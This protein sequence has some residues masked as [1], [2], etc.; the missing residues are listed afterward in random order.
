[1]LF[2]VLTA[3]SLKDYATRRKVVID[4][5][6][7][8]EK[9]KAGATSASVV[10]ALAHGIA[11]AKESIRMLDAAIRHFTNFYL[12]RVGESQSYPEELIDNE[13]EMISTELGLEE[14]FVRSLRNR[15]EEFRRHVSLY[16]HR[17]GTISPEITQ[18]DI[19][20]NP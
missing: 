5:S 15:L 4:G 3:E 13:L 7:S 2:S 1:M 8:L 10:E 17:A 11:K 14:D 20:I 9:M 6:I 18:N 19:L 16:K 12:E